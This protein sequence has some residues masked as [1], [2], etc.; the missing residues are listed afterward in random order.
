[1]TVIEK[2]FKKEDWRKKLAFYIRDH[3]GKPFEWGANDCV[4]FANGCIREM[5]DIDP[6]SW[7]RGKYRTAEEAKKVLWEHKNKGLVDTFSEVYEELGFQESD[8]SEVGDILFMW[9]TGEEG[10]EITMGVFVEES[11]NGNVLQ[12]AC[13]PGEEGLKKIQDYLLVKAWRV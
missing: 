2:T 12:Y 8:G 9:V 13:G 4:T 11:I 6:I 5:T 10:P 7:G 1:M 3:A